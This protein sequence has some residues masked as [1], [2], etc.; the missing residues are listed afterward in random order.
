MQ[1]GL[2][3]GKEEEEGFIWLRIEE[4][5]EIMTTGR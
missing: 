4:L 3:I 5:I 2:R 1:K